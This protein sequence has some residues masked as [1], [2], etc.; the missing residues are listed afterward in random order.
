MTVIC[1]AY[2]GQRAA[3]A[4]DSRLTANGYIDGAVKVWRSGIG[5][6]GFAGNEAFKRPLLGDLPPLES[7]SVACFRDW[8]DVVAGRV[9]HY[10][11]A[12][13]H[14]EVV[15]G[16]WQLDL[17]MLFACPSGIMAMPCDF[18]VFRVPRVFHAIGSG[19]PEER[20]SMWTVVNAD[21]EVLDPAGLVR[22]GVMAACAMDASCG[23]DVQVLEVTR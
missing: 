3:M 7:D 23:G 1:A 18:G 22:V 8:C 9:E 20:G 13:G 6:V 19:G 17:A 12:R 10:A 14:G 21:G 2:D 15:S 5:L 11:K 16:V 4:A